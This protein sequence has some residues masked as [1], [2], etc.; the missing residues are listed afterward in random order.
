MSYRYEYDS[1]T[2]RPRRGRRMRR[3]TARIKVHPVGYGFVVPDDNSEDVHVAGAQPRRRD[4]RRHR[5]DR[6]LARPARRRGARACGSS[7]AAAP[8]SRASSARAGKRARAAARRPA[9][10]GQVALIGADALAASAL[11][12]AVVAEISQLPRGGGRAPRGARAAACWATP[13]TRAPRSRRCW[14][15]R[16]S[17]TRSPTSSSG[18]RPGRPPVVTDADSDRSRRPAPHPVHDHRSRDGARLRDAVAV[19][20]LDRGRHAPVGGGGGRLALRARGDADRRRGAQARLQPVPA[21]PGDPHA[22]RGAVGAPVLAGAGGGSPGDGGA[23]R[24]RP[25][26]RGRRPRTSWRR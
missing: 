25:Q 7:S 1:Q 20:R 11:G 16:T 24:L 22:A 17:R 4:G 12:Q 18:R 23:H 14:R 10:P 6:G 19:E 2:K 5:R 8:R 3:L 9:D 13:T 26:R 21:E 15:W